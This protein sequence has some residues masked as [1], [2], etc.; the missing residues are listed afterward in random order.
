MNIIIF[1]V[2]NTSEREWVRKSWKGAIKELISIVSSVKVGD[3][4]FILDLI[5]TGLCEKVEK[6]IPDLLRLKFLYAG[7][8]EGQECK[9]G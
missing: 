2:G 6:A 3:D 1:V 7:K 4:K 9:E 8:A 5:C